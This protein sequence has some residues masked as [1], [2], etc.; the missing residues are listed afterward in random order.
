VTAAIPRR[1]IPW[2]VR[3]VAALT[4]VVGVV[5]A[6]CLVVAVAATTPPSVDAEV[7]LARVTRRAAAVSIRTTTTSTTTGPAR[8]AASSPPTTIASPPPAPAA[9][10]PV[11]NCA[12]ALAYLA[13]HQAPGFVATCAPGSAL[14]HYGFA[15]WNRGPCPDGQRIVHIACPLPFVYMNEAHNTWTLLGVGS[16]IDPY[17]QG[18]TA[19]QAY[20]DRLR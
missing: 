8:A 2:R 12:A 3:R 5:A 7:G 16:G 19:E 18:G 6:G 9:P 10:P 14:G 11:G 4:A 15:C 1:G 20:C 17:G 13:A